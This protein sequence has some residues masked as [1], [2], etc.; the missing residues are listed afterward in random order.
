MKKMTNWEEL[1]WRGLVKDVAGDDIADKINNESVTFYWGTDPTADSLHIGHYSSLVTAKRLMMMGHKP[2]LL[3]GGATGR[4]GDPR[5]T[6]EREIISIEQLEK[7]IQGIRSQIDRLFQGK[8]KLVN[9]YDW[10]K[11]YEFLDFLRDVGKYINVNYMLSK[12]IINRRLETGITYAEFSYMLIQGYDFLNMYRNMGCIMQVEGSDQW[13]NI[14]TGIDLIRKIDGKEAYAFTMPLILDANGNKFGKSEGNALWLDINKTSSYELYQYLIN[15]DDSM[16]EHYLKV[17][18][19]LT[20][21]EIIDVVEKHNKEPHLRIGQKTL[22]K[23]IITDIHGEEEYNKAEQISKALFSGDLTGLSAK[24]ILIGMK[25][26]PSINL[27]GEIKLLDLLVDN[28]I[29]SSRREAREMLSSNAISLNN[30]KFTDEN[31][32]VDKNMAIDG[33]V[34]VIRKGK[35]K[36][37]IGIFD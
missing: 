34:I 27:S 29:C 21:E 19:F 2:I 8:A 9:N 10:F 5:P 35:K 4:I 6:A 37:F 12:D 17:F 30:I 14:T 7:N 15:T 32:F 24:D 23:C 13:G 3:C 16:I 31:T 18:T 33:K 20:P 11:G 22:A 25:M 28:G 26:V 1:Q 36:Q